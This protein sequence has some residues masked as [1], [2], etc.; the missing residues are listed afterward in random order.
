MIAAAGLFGLLAIAVVAWMLLDLRRAD[1]SLT[2]AP[3]SRRSHGRVSVVVPMRNE[4]ANVDRCLTALRTQ[5]Y[6]DLE[7]IVADDGSDDGTG[8]KLREWRRQWLD[9][10]VLELPA[11]PP[12]WAGKAHALHHGAARAGGDW[13]LF[14]DADV[15]LAPDAV[16]RAVA[17]AADRHW[18]VLSLVGRLL[19]LSWAERVL[20]LAYWVLLYVAWIELPGM[21]LVGHFTLLRRTAYDA[22]GGFAAIA[23][24]VST[25]I[26]L[27]ALLAQHGVH[28]RLRMWP[29]AFRCR[30]YSSPK[31]LWL[32]TT[33]M[34]AAA[35]RFRAAP[36]AALTVAFAV[37]AVLPEAVA[38]LW[39]AGLLPATFS[40]LLVG[41]S[42]T[43]LAASSWLAAAL[44]ARRLGAPVALTIVKPLG[45]LGLLLLLA[46][47]CRRL[48]AGGVTWRGRRYR[49]QAPATGRVPFPAAATSDVADPTSPRLTVV[50]TG[51]DG[52]GAALPSSLAPVKCAPGVEVLLVSDTPATPPGGD[53]GAAVRCLVVRG[54]SRG[55]RRRSG[56]EAARAPLVA[57][58]ASE[59]DYGARWLGDIEA[60]FAAGDLQLAAG[61]VRYAGDEPRLE[62]LSIHRWGH[63]AG[64]DVSYPDVDN[65]AGRRDALLRV[66]V[67]DALE[68]EQGELVLG[69]LAGA[70]GI[71]IGPRPGMV[72]TAPEPIPRR[73]AVAA[74]LAGRLAAP[75]AVLGEALASLGRRPLLLAAV[76]RLLPV[77]VAADSARL[78]LAG[79]RR[80]EGA[81][82]PRRRLAVACWLARLTALDLALALGGVLAP[83]W[84]ERRA[85]WIGRPPAAGVSGSSLEPERMWSVVLRMVLSPRWRHGAPRARAAAG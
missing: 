69:V 56:L 44:V 58:A 76:R 9:L 4:A 14:L 6:G 62:A 42:A 54:A 20:L 67:G 7:V 38:V 51:A 81:G 49:E 37:S 53:Q 25:D 36:V 23:G 15:E 10:Q 52:V 32:G 21:F 45:D 75:G 83:G 72:T 78:S 71:S 22:V 30:M 11:P 8:E 50:V 3:D 43:A 60:A 70:A 12:G 84:L 28:A 2:P 63:L 35:N 39:L 18:P 79:L 65:L 24:A 13:L 19:F 74:L 68:R 34:M 5:T 41:A 29:A 17:T 61:P 31:S 64:A 55:Q 27:A 73:G 26:A 46:D 82:E 40:S 57:F 47:T 85:G 33:R 16:A 48:V 1:L 77:L 59:L 80:R 66:L